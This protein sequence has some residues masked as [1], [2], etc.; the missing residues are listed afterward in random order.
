MNGIFKVLPE[1]LRVLV[2]V[3]ESKEKS[4]GRDEQRSF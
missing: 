2:E 4:L 1:V 3:G